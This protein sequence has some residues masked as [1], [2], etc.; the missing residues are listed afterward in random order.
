M[1]FVLRTN[2]TFVWNVATTVVVAHVLACTYIFIGRQSEQWMS[3]VLEVGDY[4]VGETS[5]V[6]DHYLLAFYYVMATMTTNGVVGELTP[7]TYA[8]VVFCS[9][10]MVVNMTLFAYILGEIS[11]LIMKND[12]QVRHPPFRTSR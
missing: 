8:E 9:I 11:T 12:N 2:A 6:W 5:D 7:A 10:L 3:R 1:L 4:G